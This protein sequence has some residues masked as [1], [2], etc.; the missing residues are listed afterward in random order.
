[1]A[2]D[3]SMARMKL[4]DFTVQNKP[5]WILAIDGDEVFEKRMTYEAAGLI[6]QDEF[7]AVEFRLFDFWGD[8]NHYRVDGGWDPWVKKVRMLFKYDPKQT[9]SWQKRRIHC[10]RIPF[11]AGRALRVYQSDIRVKHFGWIE[12]KDIEAKFLRYK[13]LDDSAHLKSVLDAPDR[14]KLEEWIPEKILPF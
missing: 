12:K 9:Y 6:D 14:I 5:E 11:E 1:M 3:E 7:D 10:G 13:E 4:W 2:Q 8:R